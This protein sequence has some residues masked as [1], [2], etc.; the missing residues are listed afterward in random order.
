MGWPTWS[1]QEHV[2]PFP[3]G[4]STRVVRASSYANYL[5]TNGLVVARRYGNAAKETRPRPSCPAAYP[6]RT[7]VQIDP[8]AINDA[9]SGIHCCIQQQPAGE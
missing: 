7:V 8:M 5:V 6:G 9:G 4:R 2:P 1:T 3:H